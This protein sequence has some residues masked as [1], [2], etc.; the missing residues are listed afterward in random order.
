MPLDLEAVRHCC[1]G[2]E[3]TA[4]RQLCRAELERV[5]DALSG[6]EPVI[7]ACTQEAPLFSEL[8]AEADTAAS[9]VNIRESAGW[10][11]DAKLA[12]PKMA[13]LIAA[14]LRAGAG[15]ANRQSGQR[16]RHADLRQGRAG[17]RSGQPAQGPARRHRADQAA[18]RGAAAARDPVR[19]A[20][21]HGAHGQGHARRL[22]ADARRLCRAG[23][24][25]ARRDSLSV[26]RARTCRPAATSCSICPAERRCFRP[27]ICATAICAPTRAIRPRACAPCSRRAS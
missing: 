7:I 8:A 23:A 26:R 11:K 18:G 14:A 25:L 17:A 9:F 1:R 27:P 6:E 15:R 21:G 3:V 5:Q 2:A 16:R 12:G 10:S 22:R 4:G 19:V 20:Q 24:F 13:A